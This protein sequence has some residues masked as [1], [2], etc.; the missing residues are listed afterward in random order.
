MSDQ[1]RGLREWAWPVASM[2]QRL[3]MLRD[4]LEHRLENYGDHGLGEYA[5]GVIESMLADAKRD[6]LAEQAKA[7]GED[8]AAKGIRVAL[9]GGDQ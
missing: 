8:A 1:M 3:E 5:V 4:E 6:R 2:E 7:A 9:P